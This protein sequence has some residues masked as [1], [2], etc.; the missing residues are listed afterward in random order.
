MSRIV[1]SGWAESDSRRLLTLDDPLV[2]RARGAAFRDV[3]IYK[4]TTRAV[5]IR[6]TPNIII[7]DPLHLLHTE[8][9]LL[10]TCNGVIWGLT[11]YVS[12]RRSPVFICAITYSCSTELSFWETQD[13]SHSFF[14]GP[15]VRLLNGATWGL[16]SCCGLGKWSEREEA[17][18]EAVITCL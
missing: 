12:L 17:T 8:L 14:E 7:G 2:P 9:P 13:D 18:A 5:L 16:R 3:M 4:N 15:D 11:K 10:K 6:K 1:P